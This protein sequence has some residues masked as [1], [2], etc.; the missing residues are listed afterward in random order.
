MA[1]RSRKQVT[2]DGVVP[3]VPVPFKESEAIDF[4]SLR[5]AVEFIASRNMAGMC[6]PA[7]GSEF[8]KLS[9]DERIQCVEITIETN[10]KR[11]PVLA[12]ANHPNAMHAAKLAKRYQRMGADVIS[13]AIPRQFVTSPA[14]VL[15][16]CNRIC[17][18]VSI[19]VL[20]QDFNPGGAT[21][22]ADF[23]AKLHRKHRNFKFAK[24]EEPMII[25]KLVAIRDTVGDKVDILEGWGGYYMLEAIPVGIC[26][27]MPGT[28]YCELLDLIFTARKN[29]EDA[30]AH[31]LFG[32]V[33][34]MMNFTLQ[35]F[36][37]FLQ[38]E[39]RMLVKRGIF[40]TH[41]LRTLTLTPSRETLKYANFLINNLLRL[42]KQNGIEP[43]AF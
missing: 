2:L 27:I 35:N 33:A 3:V 14:D 1:K 26:G 17:D 32:A 18:A 24:L 7:Y 30:R 4:P 20:I 15:D 38:V 42:M 37:L 23:I 8:Y 31:D 5:R 9:D 10:N 19:P 21:I 28:P 11:I 22:D 25:D 34:P 40:K 36:E 29:G 41:H 6:I 39:K 13:F 16:Y 43:K 12:Q